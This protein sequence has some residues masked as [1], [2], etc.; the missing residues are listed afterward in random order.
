MVVVRQLSL[1]TLNSSDPLMEA[2][3]TQPGSLLPL[4]ITVTGGMMG[5]FGK[6]FSYETLGSNATTHTL[7]PL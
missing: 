5:N 2:V 3:T 1:S 4:W 7:F 6:E